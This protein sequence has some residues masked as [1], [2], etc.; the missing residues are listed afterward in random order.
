MLLDIISIHPS[1]VTWAS[2]SLSCP[3]P[4]QKGWGGPQHSSNKIVRKMKG[5]SCV[6]GTVLSVSRV[7]SL[8]AKAGGYK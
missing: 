3:V 7:T 2:L 1:S 4:N 8:R 6:S 5:N